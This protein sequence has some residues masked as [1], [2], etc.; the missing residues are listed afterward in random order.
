MLSLMVNELFEPPSVAVA[1][2]DQKLWRDDL[3]DNRNVTE[4]Y[5]LMWDF[6]RRCS[7][8]TNAK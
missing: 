8:P 1:A 2:S 4:G 3:S 7:N 5:K 6:G